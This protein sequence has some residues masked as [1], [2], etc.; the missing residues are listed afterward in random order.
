MEEAGCKS[1][2][3]DIMDGH[4]VPNISFGPGL[5]KKLR[6]QVPFFFDCHLMVEEA[7]PLFPAFKEAGC[8]LLTIS[9]EAT[10][11]IH[12][13]IQ[14]IHRLGMKAGIALNPASPPD[15]LSSILEDVDLVLIMS[16]NPGFGG[17]DFIPS[18]L[19]KIRKV[20]QMIDKSGKE[21]ILEVDGGIKAENIQ[22]VKEAGCDWFVAGSAVF[23]QEET[24]KNFKTLQSLVNQAEA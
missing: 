2:H 1:L 10:T 8:D 11:H 24:G 16:V 13:A 15:I 4:F 20:R 17:Q 6:P 7:G 23:G 5:V 22:A 12:R 18:S 14:E 3:L 9:W 21:V 19:D